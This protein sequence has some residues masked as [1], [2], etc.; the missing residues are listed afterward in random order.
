MQFQVVDDD[1]DG[2]FVMGDTGAGLPDVTT[3]GVV[4]DDLW[5]Q[6]SDI[7]TPD[8]VNDNVLNDFIDKRELWITERT[9]VKAPWNSATG[10]RP[11]PMLGPRSK[12]FGVFYDE[13][14]TEILLQNKP[15]IWE[16]LNLS[17]D[18]HVIHLHQVR[19]KILDR[20]D[21]GLSYHTFSYPNGMYRQYAKDPS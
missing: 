19:F 4:Y 3:F 10:G 17:N 1:L 7:S 12:P 8:V 21:I 20:L 14:A 15:T 5:Q 13:V 9:Q 11:L 16:F 2:D 18:A 6:L